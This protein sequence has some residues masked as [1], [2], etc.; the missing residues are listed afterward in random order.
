LKR[1]ILSPAVLPLFLAA[2]AFSQS[3]VTLTLQVGGNARHSI[4]HVPAG[5]SKP[6]VVFFIHGAGGSGANFQRETR[7]DATADREKFIAVYPSASGTGAGGTWEDMRGTGNFPFF[8]AVI[9]TLDARY[10]IDRNRIYMTGFSQGGFI[11]FAAACFF[12]DVFAAVAPVSGHAVSPC[13]L[14]RPVPVFMTWGANEGTSFLNDLTLWTGLNK[15]PTNPTVTRNY[16]TTAANA[17]GTLISYGPC[18]KGSAVLMDSI[19]GQGHQWPG[20]AN[21]NHAD[22]VWSFFKKYS[23]EGTTGISAPK[24]ALSG[25]GFS[26]SYASGRIR[27]AGLREAARVRVTD[28]RGRVVADADATL[29]LPMQ[30]RPGGVYVVTVGGNGSAMARKVLVP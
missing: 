9:D 23:L 18:D 29:E 26:V 2:A 7:G 11:S 3:N 22:E 24:P 5:I 15:C 17:R 4:A 6:P 13:T 8:Q 10:D 27:L 12:S 25:D 21:G 19:S 30:G 16:P 28:T 14:K 20:T 1:P